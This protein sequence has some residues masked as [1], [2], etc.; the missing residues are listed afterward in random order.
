P[1][2]EGFSSIAI[3]MLNNVLDKKPEYIIIDLKANN[4]YSR[5]MGELILSTLSRLEFSPYSLIVERD[6]IYLFK[7]NYGKS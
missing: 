2:W 7:L 3:E 4:P 5:A 1:T 6:G